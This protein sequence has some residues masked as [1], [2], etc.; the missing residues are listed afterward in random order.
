V[1]FELLTWRLPWTLINMTPFKLGAT[2][3]QGGRPEVP[4]R[5]QLPGPDSA[6]WAGLDAYVQLMRDCWAQRPTDRPSFDEVVG[7]LRRLLAET[8]GG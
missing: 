1:L 3:R 2:I 4:A 6:S 5:D 7:R 8:A